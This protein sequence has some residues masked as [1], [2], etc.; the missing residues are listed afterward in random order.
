[1][2]TLPCILQVAELCPHK[3]ITKKPQCSDL[4]AL[5]PGLLIAKFPVGSEGFSY[6]WTPALPLASP[7]FSAGLRPSSPLIEVS[8][9]QADRHHPCL[10]LWTLKLTIN[11]LGEEHYPTP[12]ANSVLI[13][14]R[15]HVSDL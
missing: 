15:T 1:M 13:V 12:D 2:K 11:E 8:A 3:T 7:C 4:E 9:P 6:F 14:Q 5:C 10:L